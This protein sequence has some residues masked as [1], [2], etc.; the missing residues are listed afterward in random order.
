MRK[1]GFLLVAHGSRKEEANRVVFSLVKHLRYCFRTDMFEV[2][3]MELASPSIKE[4]IKALIGKGAEELVISPFF[5]F[6]GMHYSRD[7]PALIE[8]ALNETDPSVPVKMLPPIGMYPGIINL[9]QE[10][11]YKEMEGEYEFL[12]VPPGDIEKTS[13][14][15]IEK[16]MWMSQVDGLYKPIIKRVVHATGDLDFIGNL[17]FSKDAIPAGL[18]ALR[19]KRIIYTDVN[20][21]HAGITKKM[22][23]TVECMINRPEVQNMA[24]KERLTRAATAVRLLKRD[25]NG[26]IVVIG[27]APTALITLVDL[28][29]KESIKPALVV[30]TPVGFVNARESKEYLMSLEDVPYITNRGHKGG[31]AVAS[32]IINA[33]IKMAFS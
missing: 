7:V 19:D 1:K 30:G 15:I 28:I 21:V 8:E 33:M 31:S 25:L 13:L 10:M 32:A 22:G 11:I 27:N 14:D 12:H 2:G 9:I 5:L 18:Q 24:E 23:H 4:G 26:N 17:V 16:Y 3:F 6:T 29:K 20:M